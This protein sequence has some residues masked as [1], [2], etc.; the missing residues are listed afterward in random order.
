[1]PDPTNESLLANATQTLHTGG[2]VQSAFPPPDRDSVIAAWFFYTIIALLAVFENLMVVTAFFI[3]DKLRTVTNYFV[4]GLAIA[5]IMVGAISVPLW[6]YRLKAYASPTGNENFKGVETFYRTMDSFA[7]ISSILHLMA[8]SMERYFCVGWAVKHRNTPKYVYYIALFMVWLVSALAACVKLIIPSIKP[9]DRALVTPVVFFLL[10][11]TI[12]VVAYAA[13]WKIATTRMNN[14][15]SKRSLKRE[16][17]TATTIAFV[18]GFF[19][20]AW[21]PFFVTLITVNYCTKCPFNWSALI[22]YKFLHYSNSSIN[23]IV[24]GVR[25]P[26]FRKTF[27]FIIKRIFGRVF[28]P[29]TLC[30]RNQ[31]TSL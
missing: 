2:M 12:I 14:N 23:P 28:A 21:T 30:S 13:I 31:T 19:L 11:L 5:D 24:Y 18:I 3:N 16:I 7:G 10:P 22:F 9:K 29:C 25:I 26:E 4:V 15:P 20:V 6:M 1:M 17:R 8:I 27:K